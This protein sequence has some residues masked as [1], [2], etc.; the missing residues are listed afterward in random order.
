MTKYR[1]ITALFIGLTIFL[2]AAFDVFIFI[3]GG[4][5]ATISWMIFEWSHAHPVV[6]FCF[7]FIMGHLFWQM[8]GLSK[9][10]SK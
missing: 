10:R 1:K 2:I 6:P 5:E 4:T 8:K 9:L 7:G 3:K